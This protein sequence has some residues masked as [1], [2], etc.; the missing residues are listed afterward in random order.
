M[1]IAEIVNLL[2][3]TG[4]TLDP[5]K[6]EPFPNQTRYVRQARIKG[7]EH[8]H[9][10]DVFVVDENT[11]FKYM[12]EFSDDEKFWANNYFAYL[13]GKDPGRHKGFDEKDLLNFPSWLH[14]AL[15]HLVAGKVEPKDLYILMLS[16]YDETTD[17]QAEALY[18][19]EKFMNVLTDVANSLF[20]NGLKPQVHGFWNW[21][22]TYVNYI[23]SCENENVNVTLR[24]EEPLG[25][26][27]QIVYRERIPFKTE[28]E[29]PY[30]QI[31]R[32]T[33][34]VDFHERKIYCSQIQDRTDLLALIANDL[35]ENK[36]RNLPIRQETY[37]HSISSIE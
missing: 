23:I 26:I 36:W 27:L 5:E 18:K 31:K 24:W 11:L 12:L 4:F 13:K 37:C 32:L 25:E 1:G 22:W 6:D 29:S 34:P 15:E 9:P 35:K 16:I 3:N 21:H 10:R 28:N 17:I 33:K 8:L 7:L 19:N 2:E 14:P 30:G 20:T